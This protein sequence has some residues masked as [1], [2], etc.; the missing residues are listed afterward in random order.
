M[1]EGECNSHKNLIF[2]RSPRIENEPVLSRRLAL[3]ASLAQGRR[4]F[5]FRL[6]CHAG[7]ASLQDLVEKLVFNNGLLSGRI[8]FGK[9]L[10]F[11]LFN[12]F[13]KKC[14]FFSLGPTITSEKFAAI[15]NPANKTTKVNW[16]LSWPGALE[17]C[18]KVVV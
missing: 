13:C 10:G 5:L 12:C 3:N 17:M 6:F 15:V 8:F 11:E 4:K 7:Q 1:V 14:V 2:K 18:G 9:G 16:A